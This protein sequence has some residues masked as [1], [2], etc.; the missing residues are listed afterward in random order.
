MTDAFDEFYGDYPAIEDELNAA[1]TESL[2]PRSPDVVYDVVADLGLPP[3]STVLDVGC[4][5]G[6]QA[7]ELVSRFGFTVIGVDPVARHVEMAAGFPAVRGVTESLPVADASVDL[8]WCREALY[9]VPVLEDAFAEW[10]RVLRPVGR[11]V[12]YQ[13][14]ATD[15]LEVREAAWFWAACEAHPS[16]ADRGRFEAAVAAAGLRIADTIDLASETG[17]WAEE[18]SGKASRELLAAARLLRAPERYIERFGRAAY[19][20]KLA[21]A[22]WHVFRMIG[23][24]GNRIDVLEK[25]DR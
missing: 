19:D 7:A 15:R 13:L 8:V 1:L 9:H 6:D 11:A 3:A 20:I 16:S 21:D 23:K 14:F 22:C 24:L 25:G 17:E 4:G 18:H 5:E 12:V 2:D 10:R